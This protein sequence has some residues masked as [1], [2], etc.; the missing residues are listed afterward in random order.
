[1]KKLYSVIMAAIMTF[2][3]FSAVPYAE[4][5]INVVVNGNAIDFTGEQEPVIQNGRTLV[6]FRAVFEK[7]GAD[8]KWFEDIKLCEATYGQ[9]TVG[10]EIGST[11]VTIGDGAHIPSDV[12]AQIINGRTM[13]PLR[14]LSESIGAQ[15]EWDSNTKTVTV[16]APENKGDAPGS[17][18]YEMGKGGGNNMDSDFMIDYEY[19]VVTSVYTMADKLNENIFNDIFNAV[20]ETLSTYSG[21][22]KLLNVDCNVTVNDSGIFSLQYLIDGELFYEATYGII[23]GSKIDDDTAMYIMAGPEEQ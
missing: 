12:P 23:N 22:K 10:I 2:T 7:L 17:V 11:D 13:V 15:V 16:N 9:V 6:P 5:N 20:D 1:M 19:P 8:V 18:E 4:G 3:V 21:D 14:V